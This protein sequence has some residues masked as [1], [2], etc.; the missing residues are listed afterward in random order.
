MIQQIVIQTLQQKILFILIRCQQIQWKFNF[1]I[2]EISIKLKY[3]SKSLIKFIY[4][5]LRFLLLSFVHSFIM[6]K[7]HL[8]NKKERPFEK[9][10]KLQDILSLF[11]QSKVPSPCVNFSVKQK[12]KN[13]EGFIVLKQNYYSTQLTFFLNVQYTNILISAP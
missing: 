5:L 1:E 11:I 12:F 9:I 6:P 13:T 8:T 4:K 10:K 2:S 3:L 7:A